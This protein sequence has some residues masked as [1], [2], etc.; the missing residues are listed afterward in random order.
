MHEIPVDLG[1]HEIEALSMG[2]G[3]VIHPHHLRHGGK[4]LLVLHP[5]T[6][7]KLKQ[8]HDKR[9]HHLLKLKKG[10]GIWDLLKGGYSAVYDAVKPYV[11]KLG[12]QA[13]A[14]AGKMMAQVLA[15]K[16]DLDPKIAEELG[17]RLGGMAGNQAGKYIT[18]GDTDKGYRHDNIYDT[19]KGAVDEVVPPQSGRKKTRAEMLRGGAIKGQYSSS[20][21]IVEPPTETTIAQLGSPYARTQSAQMNPPVPIRNQNGGYNP[22]GKPVGGIMSGGSF[23]PAGGGGIRHRR[24]HN[25]TYVAI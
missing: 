17:A 8:S 19:V 4:H 23:A 10:E 11:P 21:G 25:K 9:K 22:L 7:K 12:E 20:R 6:L 3:I 2:M 24:R 18:S 14:K 1:K 15:E 16:F 5:T 13:G